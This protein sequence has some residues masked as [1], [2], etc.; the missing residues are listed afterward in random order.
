MAATRKTKNSTA[1]SAGKAADVERK[2]LT[3]GIILLVSLLVLIGGAVG[4]LWWAKSRLFAGNPR[5]TLHEIEVQS[6]G[7]WAQNNV[8]RSQLIRKVGLK[9]G[10]DNLMAI[11]IAKL[12]KTLCSI[13]NVADARVTLELPNK[14]TIAIDER[15]P[16][17][18]LGKKDGDLVV[19]G[20]GVVLER[21]ECFGTHSH[22]PVILLPQRQMLNAVPGKVMPGAAEP[23]KLLTAVRGS[24][25]FTLKTIFIRDDKL[26]VILDYHYGKNTRSYTVNMSVGNYEELLAQVKLSIDN[27]LLRNENHTVVNV[28]YDG[29]T[30]LSK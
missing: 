16:W 17:A 10:Q 24:K 4:L 19:D 22:L 26:N 5:F 12:R 14:L 27:S 6:T 1:V 20:E 18:F 21:R 25:D 23:L 28:L 7:Y 11:D 9:L 8:N 15:V 3:R 13:P 30:V 29:Q 2:K